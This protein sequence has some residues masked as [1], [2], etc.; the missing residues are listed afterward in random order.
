VVSDVPP[1]TSLA[2]SFALHLILLGL[3]IACAWVSFIGLGLPTRETDR[4]LFYSR[5]AWSGKEII[6]LTNSSSVNT[7]D[8]SRG[9]DV[10]ADAIRPTTQPVLLNGTDAQRAQIVRRYRLMSNLP[11]EFITLKALAEM[12][13]RSGIDRFDPRLYQYGG[14][15]IYP[16]GALVKLA[17]VTGFVASPP[18]GVSSLEFYL[19]R[20]DEFGK[21]YMLLRGMSMAWGVLLVACVWWMVH[22]STGHRL[23]ATLTSIIVMTLPVVWAMAIEAKPHMGG[24]ALTMLS[25]CLGARYVETG[26]MRWLIATS[27]AAGAAAGI[28][29]SGATAILVPVIA[30]VWRRDR[31]A[32]RLMLSVVIVAAVFVSTNPFTV[33]NA[34]ARPELLA[35]NIDNTRAMYQLSI[36][37]SMSALRYLIDAVGRVTLCLMAV[38]FLITWLRAR[39]NRTAAVEGHNTLEVTS[40][41]PVILASIVGVIVLVPYAAMGTGKSLEYVRFAIVPVVAAVVLA[42]SYLGRNLLNRKLQIR[43]VL[44]MLLIPVVNFAM[45]MFSNAQATK[46]RFNESY[47]GMKSEVIGT[48]FEPAPWSMPPV[49]LFTCKIELIPR[50]TAPAFATVIPANLQT[51]LGL[52]LE[53]S[54]QISWHWNTFQTIG[55]LNPETKSP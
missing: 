14:L 46:D 25:A 40:N 5:S 12:N 18:A 22:R 24:A 3:V 55:H 30:V 49:D 38:L 17:T 4:F 29:L 43:H 42:V 15:W 9:A 16:A 31:V 39:S 33:Y 34:I 20:P 45:T 44:I 53:R 41:V 11:D 37:G 19:D 8:R 2:K 1:A 23:L 32:T 47:Q 48:S 50:G 54:E 35:S 52:K 7:S 26:R 13:T 10:D 51:E 6:Q 27:L 36:A 28:V 21:F